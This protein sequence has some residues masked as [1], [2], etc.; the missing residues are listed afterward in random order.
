VSAPDPNFAWT[1]ALLAEMA[2]ELVESKRAS[3]GSISELAAGWLTPQYPGV[4]GHIR[5]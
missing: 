2:V 3:G 4:S 5:P 1:K